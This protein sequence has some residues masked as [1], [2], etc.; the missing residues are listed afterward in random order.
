MAAMTMN[1]PHRRNQDEKFESICR[2][3]FAT[4]ATAANEA[5]L[6]P[7]ERAHIC[8]PMQLYYTSQGF[9]PDSIRL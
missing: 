8:D 5:D 7:Y 2:N 4:I 6:L 9:H 1:F 3:C